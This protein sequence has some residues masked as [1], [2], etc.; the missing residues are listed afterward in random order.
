M[1]DHDLETLDIHTFNLQSDF[2]LH[3]SSNMNSTKQIEQSHNKSFNYFDHL[4]ENIPK[5]PSGGSHHHAT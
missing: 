1:K 2:S 4:K 5:I 3:L